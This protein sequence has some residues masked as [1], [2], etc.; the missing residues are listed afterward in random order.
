MTDKQTKI[1]QQEQIK[2]ELRESEARFRAIVE[3]SQ[4][5]ILIV[6][7]NFEFTY[8]N[9]MLCQILDSSQ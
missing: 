4:S 1:N 8:V 9:D 2:R 7:N 5:G 6:N 3:N